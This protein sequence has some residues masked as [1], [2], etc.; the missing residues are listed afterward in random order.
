MRTIQPKIRK[1]TEEKSNRNVRKFGYTSGGRFL[2][3]G[4]SGKL[5]RG[6]LRS[7]KTYI[8]Y[9]A[10]SGHSEP[11]K[12]LPTH[13]KTQKQ[14]V[15]DIHCLHSTMCSSVFKKKMFRNL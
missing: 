13:P 1:I 12:E 14:I 6:G 9:L 5:S 4:H 11:K 8:S 15:N 10:H 2:F 7:V 3:S